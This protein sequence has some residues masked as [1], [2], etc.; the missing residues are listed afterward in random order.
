MLATKKQNKKQSKIPLH[1]FVK[2]CSKFS[3]H[4]APAA[5][6]TPEASANTKKDM[7]QLQSSFNLSLQALPAVHN[8]A[9][10]YISN[11]YLSY[12]PGRNVGTETKPDPTITY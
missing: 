4:E 8:L 11:K 10:Y 9:Q 6:S 1:Y 12:Q 3:L 5:Q 2:M 7:F